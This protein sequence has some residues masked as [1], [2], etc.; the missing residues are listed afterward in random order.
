VSPLSH[1]FR[2]FAA[3]YAEKIHYLT[4]L[5]KRGSNAAVTVETPVTH[6]KKLL[7]HGLTLVETAV[8][9]VTHLGGRVA[10]ERT[11]TSLASTSQSIAF[12]DFNST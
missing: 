3:K 4:S 7:G 10:V 11:V 8:T 5:L 6:S 9:T 2:L 1:L 12:I